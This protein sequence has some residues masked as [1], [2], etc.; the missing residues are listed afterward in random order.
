MC[1]AQDSLG[2]MRSTSEGFLIAR[3]FFKGLLLVLDCVPLRPN[4]WVLDLMI[5]LA[6]LGAATCADS[7][8]YF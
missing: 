2:S 1:R 5:G 7:D 8:G 3:S 6:L 4:C